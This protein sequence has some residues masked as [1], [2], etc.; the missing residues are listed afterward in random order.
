VAAP[1]GNG[2]FL[3]ILLNVAIFGCDKVLHLPWCQSLYLNHANPH[4]WQFI[5]SSFCHAGAGSPGVFR[6]CVCL[7]AL[8]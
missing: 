7:V 5:T 4:W 2:V 1:P 6:W 8:T 3:L